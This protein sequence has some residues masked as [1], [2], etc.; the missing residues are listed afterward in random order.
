MLQQ[1]PFRGS[2]GSSR[3]TMEWVGL[4]TGAGSQHALTLPT[5]FPVSSENIAYVALPRVL[6]ENL[7]EECKSL[8][9][10]KHRAP[11]LH[12]QHICIVTFSPPYLEAEKRCTIS[13]CSG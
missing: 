5:W 1:P 8:R 13:F 6:A 9:V 11:T 10:I 7:K 3:E 2:H 4:W 12:Y